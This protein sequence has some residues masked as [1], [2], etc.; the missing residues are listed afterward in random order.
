MTGRDE[1]RQNGYYYDSL[2]AGRVCCDHCLYIRDRF[3][4][5]NACNVQVLGVLSFLTK[6]ESFKLSSFSRK[7]IYEKYSRLHNF[8]SYDDLV[9]DL[10]N[11]KRDIYDS[12]K[13]F[14]INSRKKQAVL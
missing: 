13:S 8:D 7:D 5:R 9:V 1:R 2:D 12:G 6:V 3:L 14:Y 10:H 11:C 4:L